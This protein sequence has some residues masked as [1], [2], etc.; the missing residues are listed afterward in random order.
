MNWIKIIFSTVLVIVKLIIPEI[1]QRGRI[2]KLTEAEVLAENKKRRRENE[3]YKKQNPLGIE[4]LKYRDGVPIMVNYIK[5]VEWSTPK[6]WRIPEGMKIENSIR[7][8]WSASRHLT[9]I[10]IMQ[11]GQ[12]I[13]FPSNYREAVNELSAT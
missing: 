13:H 9:A 10:E 3:E 6:H 12:G 1:R 11:L 2:K 5:Y 4:W 8:F 7:G